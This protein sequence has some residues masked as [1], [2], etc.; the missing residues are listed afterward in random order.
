MSFK[1]VTA[2]IV[3][4]GNAQRPETVTISNTSEYRDLES[5]DFCGTCENCKHDEQIFFYADSLSELDSLVQN[6]HHDGWKIQ[7]YSVT[8]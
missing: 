6:A 8:S 5:C 7:S 3:S 2:R 1:T 4:Q